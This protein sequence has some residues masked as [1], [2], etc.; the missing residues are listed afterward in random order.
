MK[1]FVKVEFNSH[2]NHNPSCDILC[3]YID[4]DSFITY[5]VYVTEYNGIKKGSE[6]M[7]YYSGENYVFGST[8][9]SNSRMFKIY[10]GQEIPEKYR[11]AW[12]KLKRM[13]YTA[14]LKRSLQDILDVLCGIDKFTG[15]EDIIYR[16]ASDSVAEEDA[17]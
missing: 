9:K 17:K 2:E 5:G 12:L 13:Y 8:K 1:K 3:G 16:I 6:F 14:D 7:E 10:E 15:D 11:E 4:K